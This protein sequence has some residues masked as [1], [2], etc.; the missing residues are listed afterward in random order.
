MSE[1]TSLPTQTSE[2]AQRVPLTNHEC[3]ELKFDARE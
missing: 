1:T 3:Y 2:A